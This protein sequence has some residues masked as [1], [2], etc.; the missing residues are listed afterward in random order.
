MKRFTFL[1]MA[2]LLLA[3]SLAFAQD[4]L[5]EPIAN[6]NAAYAELDRETQGENAQAG[7][8]WE[9]PVNATVKEST[10]V[11][12]EPSTPKVD[13]WEEEWQKRR[14]NVSFFMGFFPVTALG[15]I[16]VA[17]VEDIAGE[18]E[19][20]PD[21][22]AYSIGIGYELFYLLEVGVMVDYTTISKTPLISVIPRVK[23]NWLN[24]KYFR[25]YSYGG[26]G[27]IFW[28]DGAS[29]MF[30]FAVLGFEAGNHLSFFFEGGWGQVGLFTLG[31]K[32]AI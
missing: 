4:D 17:I 5:A 12:V 8:A 19:S 14:L 29:I 15:E 6:E 1:P 32:L 11:S 27:A 28:D 7:T 10:P 30:N 22:M 13:P 24:F 18:E 23:L 25:L 26:L 3:G 20:D 21:L 9:K 2:L 16:F 31:M